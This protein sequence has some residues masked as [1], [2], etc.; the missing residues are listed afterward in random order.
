MFLLNDSE[1]ST[2]LF[3]ECYFLIVAVTIQWNK[4][5]GDL[6]DNKIKKILPRLKFIN[7]RYRWQYHL[8]TFTT[9]CSHFYISSLST[10]NMWVHSALCNHKK[11]HILA[12]K[13]TRLLP[14]FEFSLFRKFSPHVAKIYWN[15]HGFSLQWCHQVDY[16]LVFLLMTF[17]VHTF[18]S[19]SKVNK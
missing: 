2:L 1:I 5:C 6:W 3:A 4:T 16:I 19:G 18:S 15:F 17:W 9:L 14:D 8:I 7:R 10:Y 11:L 13:R 12:N